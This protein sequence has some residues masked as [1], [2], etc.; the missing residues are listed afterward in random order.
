MLERGVA[1]GNFLRFIFYD[2][3]NIDVN[4]SDPLSLE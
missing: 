2:L 1:H 3:W 4:D